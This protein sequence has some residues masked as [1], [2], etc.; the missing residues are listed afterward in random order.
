MREGLIQFPRRWDRAD[1]LSWGID[2]H[3]SRKREDRSDNNDRLDRMSV[4]LSMSP[5][6][7]LIRSSI[8]VN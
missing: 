1:I 6:P 2:H 3:L 7:L 8:N 4:F 5:D